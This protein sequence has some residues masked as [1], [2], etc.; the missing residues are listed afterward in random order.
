M[1][2]GKSSRMGA[3]K[4]FLETGGETF[5][6]RAAGNLSK[7]CENPVKIVLNQ[8][9]KH[10]IEKLPAG[11]R[12]V[13]DVY[14]N[15]GAPGGIHAALRDSKSVWTFVLAC[16][17]PFVNGTAIEK[18]AA[19]AAGS[20]KNIAA[21]VPKQLDGKLQ[22]LCA[23]YRTDACLPKIQELLERNTSASVGD[24]LELVSVRHVEINELNIDETNDLFFNVNRPADFQLLDP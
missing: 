12:Y 2:G 24:F 9:Q 18:L 4:A 13:F 8:N 21:I 17:M 22:P 23:V 14:Q 3:D 19:I 5:L 6:S 15:R 1:A 7:V 20:N 16:D 11:V 10:F